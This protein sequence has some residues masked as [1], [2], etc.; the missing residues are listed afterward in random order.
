MYSWFPALFYLLS[1]LALMRASV[2]AA[3][4]SKRTAL[5]RVR[6]VARPDGAGECLQGTADRLLSLMKPAYTALDGLFGRHRN[7][8]AG[9]TYEC[10]G[11]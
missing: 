8:S 2:L 11:H 5:R 9:V 4:S 10:H 1:A 7:D 3:P 6:C